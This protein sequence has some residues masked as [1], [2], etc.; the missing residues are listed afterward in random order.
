MV[1]VDEAGKC[2]GILFLGDVARED[3]ARTVGHT[4]EDISED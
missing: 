2:V 3:S 4:L 1:I